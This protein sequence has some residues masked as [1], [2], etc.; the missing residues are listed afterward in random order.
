MGPDSEGEQWIAR[1]VPLETAILTRLE[2]SDV[3][4]PRVIGSITAQHAAVESIQQVLLPKL[5]IATCRRRATDFEFLRVS[6]QRAAA[7]GTR[8]YE[9]GLPLRRWRP[10]GAR[11]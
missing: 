10:V 8:V 11:P 2:A 7:T 9:P 5:F 1:A 3:R 4:A 6:A